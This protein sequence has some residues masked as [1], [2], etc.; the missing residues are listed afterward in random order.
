MRKLI[1][2]YVFLKDYEV[3]YDKGSNH[4]EH[5]YEDG[6]APNNGH[7]SPPLPHTWNQHPQDHHF[8]QGDYTYTSVG[9]EKSTEAND[10]S[11]DEYESKSYPQGSN[12]PVEY[13]GECEP[14]GDHSNSRNHFQVSGVTGLTL[15]VFADFQNNITAQMIITATLYFDIFDRVLLLSIKAFSETGK[16]SIQSSSLATSASWINFTFGVVSYKEANFHLYS[17]L[18]MFFP[19]YVS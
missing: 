10:F 4:H 12:H 8:H 13:N 1:T 3:D 7:G 15:F 5:A 17:S 19:L 18:Y 11:T 16:L 6:T 2:V 14:D 9:T